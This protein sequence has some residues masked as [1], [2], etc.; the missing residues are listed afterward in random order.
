MT[1][2]PTNIDGTDITGATIDGQEV[3]E[4]T[5]D[6]QTVFT[7][8][9]VIPASTIYYWPFDEGS[10][11]TSAEKIEGKDMSFNFENW[12]SGNF[13]GGT[14]QEFVRANN[15]EGD[16][17]GVDLDVH[18]EILFAATIDDVSNIS[19]EQMIMSTDETGSSGVL[20]FRVLSDGR[21]RFLGS[22]GSGSFI[23]ES[24]TQV[25]D[26][27]RYRVAARFDPTNTNQVA[28]IVDKTVED[29][30]SGLSSFGPVGENL[31]VGHRERGP[32]THFDGKIDAVAIHNDSTQTAIDEDFNQFFV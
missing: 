19:G 8:G 1:P 4:I 14:T 9:P 11:Q 7:A 22:D 12:V 31:G 16:A 18:D 27:E 25:N 21:L 6:G 24:T 10:G 29:T 32:D 23:A 30:D 2:P 13:V 15:N 28:V 5:I 3:Q 26:G 20:R 17:S